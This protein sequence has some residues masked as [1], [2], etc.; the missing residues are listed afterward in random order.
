MGESREDLV[1]LRK[2]VSTLVAQQKLL[3]ERMDELTRLLSA[4]IPV[5]TAPQPPPPPS[6]IGVQ[7]EVFRGDGAAR[8]AIIEYSD[9]ECPYCGKYER[10]T[11]PEVLENYIKTGKVKLFYRDL[12]LPMHPHAMAAARANRCAGEQGK[13]WEMHDS[14]FAKQNA[15]SDPALLD[16]AKTLGL[17]ADKFNDCFSSQKYAEDIQKSLADAQKMG[18][19]GTPTFFIGNIDPKGDVVNIKKKIVGAHPYET[20]QSALDELLAAKSEQTV[21]DH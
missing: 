10:E 19:D 8:V 4:N 3:I 18:I 21:S 20:F 16:R 6:T 9:F 15:L 1:N 17:E 13:Y 7:R 14:L 5:R 2:D 12:P 11:S